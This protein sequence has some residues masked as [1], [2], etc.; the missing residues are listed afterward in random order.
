[1][2]Q[3]AILSLVQVAFLLLLSLFFSQPVWAQATLENPKPGS[4]QSGL[5]IISGWACD[6]S[7]IEVRFNGGPPVDAAYGTDRGDTRGRC[8]DTDNGFGLL[9]NWNLLGDGTHTVQVLANGTEFANVTVTVTTFGEQFLRDASGEYTVSDFPQVGQNVVVRWQ[10]SQQNFVISDIDGL[11]PSRMSISKMYW[12]DSKTIQRANLDGSQK[13]TLVSGGKPYDIAL[14]VAGGKMYWTGWNGQSD[15]IQR[16]NLDGSQRETLVSSGDALYGGI[17]LDVA[18]GKMYWSNYVFGR[19]GE[20]PWVTIE[21]ANLDGSQREMLVLGGGPY[22]IALDVAGGKMYWTDYEQGTVERANLDG[23]QRETLVSGDEL[24]G[25]IALDVAGG[26]MYWTDAGLGT[27]WRANLDGSQR[28]TLVSGDDLADDSGDLADIALDVAGGKMYW[29]NPSSGTIQ[30]ANLDG[31]QRETLVSGARPGSIALSP[32]VPASVALRQES[33]QTFVTTDGSASPSSGTGGSPQRVLENPKPGSFQSGL[34]IIS[35]WVCD[36]S[37]IGVRFNGGPPVEAA[38]GT[39]RGDTQGRC[40]DTDNGFGL[41]FNWNLLGDG[42]H[43]VQVLADGTEFARA[44][45][46]VTTF[47]KEFVQGLSG[48]FTVSDFPQVGQD[49]VVRWQESQQNLVIAAAAP[50]QRL[51]DV[52]PSVTIP[53]GVTSVQADDVSVTSLPLPNRP[54]PGQS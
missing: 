10:E 27:I 13:E 49:V 43:T 4:S 26:K 44:T 35:G 50:T 15:T 42:T 51:V 37:R 23:F 36:A 28:E 21:R 19:E 20:D 53:A 7:R 41:L 48:E 17:A 6:A 16:A 32:A 8:G 1:M 9:F 31:S 5:G 12:T 46:T 39:D 25:G 22:N 45:V 24:Y 47:G 30:R 3:S 40:G 54:S 33:Q 34:G 29:T 52:S 2:R 18:G 38:Y 14:D 11:P